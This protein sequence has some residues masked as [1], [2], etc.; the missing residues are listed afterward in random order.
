M[1]KV[2]VAEETAGRVSRREGEAVPSRR[3]TGKGKKREG[4]CASLYCA[5]K[6]PEC[7][8]IHTGGY[9]KEERQKTTAFES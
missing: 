7:K 8:N 1:K 3:I 9:K 5:E 2:E 4:N 6:V